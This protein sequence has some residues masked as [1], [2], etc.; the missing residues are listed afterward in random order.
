MQNLDAPVFRRAANGSYNVRMTSRHPVLLLC[1]LGIL[2]AV[3]SSLARAAEPVTESDRWYVLLMD[4]QRVGHQHS[5][6]TR[7]GDRITTSTDLQVS[8]RRGPVAL[9]V[10]SVTTFI[11]TADGE[12]IEATSELNMGG[13]PMRTQ[14]KF[15]DSGITALQAG[16]SR[17]IDPIPGEWMPPAAVDRYVEEE[18]AEGAKRIDVRTIDW[19]LGLS[20]VEMTMSVIGEEEVE[21]FGKVVPAIAW[22][23]TQSLIPGVK[24]RQYVDA[25]GRTVRD[26]VSFGGLEM[27]T[28]LAD[29][30]LATMPFDPPELMA[31]LLIKPSKPLANPRQ[32]RRAVYELTL[33]RGGE[34]GAAL[35]LLRAGAQRVVFGDRDTAKVIVDL[36]DPANP[37]GDTPTDDDRRATRILDAG[38]EKIQA[39]TVEALTDMPDDASDHDKALRLRAFVERYIDSKDLSVGFATASDVARTAQG[40]C[41]EHA[42]L[43]AAMLRV[44]GIPSRTV[45]GLVYVDQFL[46]QSDVFGFHMWTQAWLTPVPG[47]GDR[48]VDL[49]ATLPDVAFDAA[50]IAIGASSMTDG[51]ITNDLIVI[52]PMLGTLQIKVVE[53]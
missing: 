44:A 15:T 38:D 6:Q 49:D 32:Q 1:F 35:E 36:D 8:I 20:P 43:L 50:H 37:A 11:E 5:I 3:T 22:D 28:L 24:A 42:V 19:S 9:S 10:T 33:D 34:D 52:A 45:T 41:T 16:Q 26:T 51:A 27:Q 7:E 2:V 4:G 25:R 30:Q 23:V 39:L 17:A 53:P 13:G 21:V 40:D 29:E 48:W 12:P 46:G 31:N 18:M 47:S 14:Y